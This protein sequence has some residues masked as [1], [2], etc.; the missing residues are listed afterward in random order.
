M[1]VITY[2]MGNA[3]FQYHLGWFPKHLLIKKNK[4]IP[5]LLNGTTAGACPGRQT[6]GTDP[7]AA[8][9]ATSLGS[10]SPTGEPAAQA[11]SGSPSCCSATRGPPEEAAEDT[12]SWRL[13]PPEGGSVVEGK[14]KMERWYRS[15]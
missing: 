9:Q 13:Q 3:S 8:N 15:R 1:S 12:A 5:G 10:P 7:G 11:G 6:A 2:L 4:K 14:S